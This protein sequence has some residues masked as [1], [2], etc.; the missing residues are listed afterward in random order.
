MILGEPKLTVLR[1][2][3]TYYHFENISRETTLSEKITIKNMQGGLL[4][5]TIKTDV[6]WLEVDRNELLKTHEQEL[7]IRV[8]APN[9][10]I[11]TI[12]CEG[13]VTIE[14]NGGKEIIPFKV[15][16]KEPDTVIEDAPE[17]SNKEFSFGEEKPSL[18]DDDGLARLFSAATE[19]S[20]LLQKIKEMI[21]DRLE[22]DRT[23]EQA[24]NKLYEEMKR[25]QGFSDL[26]DRNIK[27]LITDLILLYDHVKRFEASLTPLHETEFASISK[28]FKFLVD[29]LKET[30]YRQ[31]VEPFESDDSEI[32]NS[33]YQKAIKT[34][35]TD[36]EGEHLKIV[37][38]VRQGFKWRD[39]IL[40]PKEVIIKRYVKSSN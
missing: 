3:D 10:P 33:K 38:V 11:D 25:Q 34:I 7:M 9:I 21:E 30:L 32:F 1:K 36:D 39:K 31:D 20:A 23:K 12:Q 37:D 19:H 6:P 15:I 2:R 17:I 29:D 28:D 27:P 35:T 8:L 4:Q 16:L 18:K 40:R 14:T 22:Y 24:F 26:V 13:S 5:G